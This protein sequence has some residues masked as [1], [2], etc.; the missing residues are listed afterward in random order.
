MSTPEHIEV[1][2]RRMELLHERGLRYQTEY[3]L[4]AKSVQIFRCMV[5][6]NAI[7]ASAVTA[8]IK[9]IDEFEAKK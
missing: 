6:E 8:M 7:N 1:L 9:Q 5:D 4:H 2:E 3:K